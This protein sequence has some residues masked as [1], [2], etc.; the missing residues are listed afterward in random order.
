MPPSPQRLALAITLLAGGGF[1]EAAAAKTLQ[2]DAP[3]TQGKPWVAV[4]R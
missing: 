2:I 1:I 4:I 3:T